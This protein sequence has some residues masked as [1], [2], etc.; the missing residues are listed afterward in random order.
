M[1]ESKFKIGDSVIAAAVGILP[2][3]GVVD[4][5][6]QNDNGTWWCTVKGYDNLSR[7]TG[8]EIIL[9][10]LADNDTIAFKAV[11]M[12]LHDLSDALYSKWIDQH[13]VEDLHEAAKRLRRAKYFL[14][15][16]YIGD[17]MQPIYAP[18]PA[19]PQP[20]GGES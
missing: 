2:T 17:K 1:S 13:V 6:G 5:M 20:D 3:A 8:N 14:E 15:R 10:A 7:V 12:A 9:K 4:E 18:H 11:E 19:T 16:K